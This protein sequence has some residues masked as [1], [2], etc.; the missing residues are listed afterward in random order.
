MVVLT[1]LDL[2]TCN[3]NGNGNG[4]IEGKDIKE[5]NLSRVAD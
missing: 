3:G 1:Q 2:C 5:E 4:K